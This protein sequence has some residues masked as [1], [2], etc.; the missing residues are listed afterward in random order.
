MYRSQVFLHEIVH[1]R[2]RFPQAEI[3][4]NWTIGYL[5]KFPSYLYYPHIAHHKHQTFAGSEDPE[6]RKMTDKSWRFILLRPFLLSALLPF[7]QW[8][9]FGFI[10]LFYFMLSP[11]VKL[12]IF[13]NYSTLA[14]NPKYLRPIKQK[15]ELKLMVREDLR[16]C[17]F[18][19]AILAF[20]LLNWIPWKLILLMKKLH[21]EFIN[22]LKSLV[23]LGT[24]W[25]LSGLSFLGFN[26]VKFISNR[27]ADKGCFMGIFSDMGTWTFN[28]SNAEIK[29]HPWIF[30]GPA[31]RQYPVSIA[32]LVVNQRLSLG[33]K[34][35][36]Y[37]KRPSTEFINKEF[38][39]LKNKILN[40]NL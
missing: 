16:C 24:Y 12:K 4:Y 37:L 17:F 30:I 39:E 11:Q 31:S 5:N 9:R 27:N 2:A 19:L 28:H 20:A 21:L 38:S 7:F 23:F 34:I 35:N 33:V 15:N 1:L 26:L 18:A 14:F 6:Y 40:P 36:L 10:P 8:L 13:E 29:N 32:K 22:E 25:I 3:L